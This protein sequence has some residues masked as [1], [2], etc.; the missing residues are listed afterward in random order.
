MQ[1]IPDSFCELFLA[2]HEAP[3]KLGYRA[4]KELVGRKESHVDVAQLDQLRGKVDE[5]T[6]MTWNIG[7]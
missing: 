6:R 1:N 3:G 5:G 7:I 2:G 4:I